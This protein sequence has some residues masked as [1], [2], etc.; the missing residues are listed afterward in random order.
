M[1]YVVPR[2]PMLERRRHKNNF[3][4]HK[5]NVALKRTKLNER[6]CGFLVKTVMTF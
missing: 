1:D 3:R 4:L 6:P 5:A 2:Y